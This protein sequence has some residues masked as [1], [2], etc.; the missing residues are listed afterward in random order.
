MA[1]TDARRVAPAARNGLAAVLGRPQFALL[2]IGQT[3]SQLGDRLHQMALIALVEVAAEARTAGIEMSKIGVVF[4]L[5]TIFAPIVGALVDRW[6]KRTTMIACDLFRALI[7]ALIPWLYHTL[8]YIW[9]AYVVAF[10][11]G[12]AGV[13]FNAAKMALI[14][15]LVEHHQLMPAN[16][17]LA[18]IGRFAT[19]TGVVGGGVMVGWAAWQRIGWEGYEAGFYM[20][21]LSYGISV[22]TL[23]A[24]MLL[25][26]RHA[27]G[28]AAHHPIAES[29]EVVRREVQHLAG[30]M[31]TT[32]G[33][34]RTHH[35]LRFVFLM[36]MVLGALAASIWVVVTT[37]TMLNEGTRGVGF[38]GGLLAAGMI[39][40]GLL[41]G[42]VG[43]RWD[44]RWLMVIGCLA[45][46]LFM[47]AGSFAFT[48]AV[49]L[50]IAFLG[51]LLLAPVMVSMDT[52]LHEWAPP[53]ARALVFSTR[54]LV[55]GATFMVFSQVVGFGVALLEAV[56]HRPYAVGLLL[57]GALVAAGS[58]AAGA[59]QL[60]LG[61]QRADGA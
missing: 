42:S 52:L 1:V 57:A 9:P 17:A 21:S 14:P 55:L 54:D 30:D 48:Y 16:A 45:I 43:A 38:L 40:G 25:S 5:P 26:R 59:T 3:V 23:A 12:L 24:I 20:D 22:V 47:V 39:A 7:V 41:V 10:L 11:V 56:S 29:A 2:V 33:L 50:P 44:K 31:R 28:Q 60:R 53:S 8:G 4:L 19:V 32:F 15:D 27:R 49:F 35:G 58:L 18:T 13:F 61:R 46:G 51:G 34:I 6:S 37:A 36:V